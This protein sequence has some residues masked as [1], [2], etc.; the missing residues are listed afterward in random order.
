MRGGLL[1]GRA[2][3][4]GA[5]V[6]V[7]GE[8]GIVGHFPEVAVEIGETP[9]VP[10]PLRARRCLDSPGAGS[11]HLFEDGVHVCNNLWYKSRPFTADWVA[12]TL[13]SL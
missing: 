2:G 11:H 8:V 12:E 3:Q 13:R 6:R 7:K 4:R 10:A 5:P 1:V 9:R